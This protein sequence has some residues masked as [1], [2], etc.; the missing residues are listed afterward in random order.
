MER[1]A[2]IDVTDKWGGTALHHAVFFCHPHM[3][4]LLLDHG[5]KTDRKNVDGEAALDIAIARQSGL[6]CECWEWEPA[7]KLLTAHIAKISAPVP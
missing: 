6:Q 4:E 1:G 2:S 7:M 3:V 5:A